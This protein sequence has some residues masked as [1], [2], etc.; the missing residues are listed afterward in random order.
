MTKDSLPE[1]AAVPR[2]A[3]RIE[4]HGSAPLLELMRISKR[5]PGTLALDRLNVSFEAGEI[6]GLLGMNGAGKST[7]LNIIGGV[8]HPDEGEIRLRG[9]PV[10]IANPLHARQLGIAFIHQELSLFPN[11][12]VASNILITDL[13]ALPGGILREQRL[14]ERARAILE[15]MGLRHITPEQRVDSLRLGEQQLV[16]VSRC[17]AQHTEILILD[18]PTSSLTEGEIDTLFTIMR[19]LKSQGVCIVFVSHRLDEVFT[20]CDRITVLRDGCHVGTYLRAEI[21]QPTVIR[22]MLGHELGEQTARSRSQPGAPLLDVERLTRGT[23]VRD[24]TF[25]VRSGEIV[26]LTGVL[27]SGRTELVRCLFGLD[28]PDGGTIRFA[29]HPVRIRHPRDAIRLGISLITEDRKAEGLALDLPIVD[30]IA[31]ARLRAFANGFGL[32]RRTSELAAAERQ[33]QQLQIVT[34]TLQ[35]I[36][37][38]LSGG[39]QQKVVLGKWLETRPRLLLLDEPTR[40]VDIGTK[41]QVYQLVE[42]LASDGAGILFISSEIPE[43]VRVS[44]RILV[45]RRGQIVDELTGE[46]ITMRDVLS[47]TVGAS[48]HA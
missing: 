2:Q 3:K 44:H 41:E 14:R 9:R 21:D 34:P 45:M 25:Q 42:R 13:P 23:V 30:N 29:G 15:R 20:I 37:R 40:G 28:K 38:Y 35:R 4:R 18:E 26:G 8:V 5:F 27:G 47:A 31:M 19:E 10:R 43:I 22:M 46:R 6:H 33:R 36:V 24:V 39:N 48:V 11:L 12:D 32:M 16:E 1:H 7:L 17:L